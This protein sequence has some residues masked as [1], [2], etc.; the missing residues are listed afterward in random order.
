MYSQTVSLDSGDF[1]LN[2]AFFG[3]QGMSFRFQQGKINL[4]VWTQEIERRGKP[5]HSN[6]SQINNIFT[7]KLVQLS[8][9]TLCGR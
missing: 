5:S 7:L 8:P 4:L 9:V 1:R 3:G 6:F 2:R